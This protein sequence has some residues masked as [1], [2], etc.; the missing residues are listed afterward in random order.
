MAK[1]QAESQTLL[2]GMC[3][4]LQ[5]QNLKLANCIRLLNERVERLEQ[6]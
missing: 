1:N 2:L 5:E 3:S 4:E 6:K